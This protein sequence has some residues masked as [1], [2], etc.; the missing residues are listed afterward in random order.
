[1]STSPTRQILCLHGNG[2]SAAIFQAQARPLHSALK[3]RGIDLVFVQGAFPSDP[4]SG[5]MP[6]FADSGPFYSWFS[7]DGSKATQAQLMKE[8]P[9][10]NQ[11]LERQLAAKGSHSSDVVGLMGFSQ[12][13]IIASLLIMQSKVGDRR[14]SN[15]KL[16]IFVCGG[17]RPN[18]LA[19]LKE[20]NVQTPSIH[21]HGLQDPNLPASRELLEAFAPSTR[22]TLEFSG[23]H[24]M[25]QSI[26][27]NDKLAALIHEAL[28]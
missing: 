24:N 25:P 18:L 8:M 10:L 16:G 27:S 1:M 9:S 13:A 17:A 14:W 6:F 28:K 22:Q 19:S 12:G 15:V 4:G 20:M 11:S 23:G 5:V 2:T 3:S 26:D 21:A 7:Q